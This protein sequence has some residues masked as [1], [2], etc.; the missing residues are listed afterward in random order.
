MLSVTPSELWEYRFGDVLRGLAAL[1]NPEPP[2][3][4][5]PIHGLGPCLGTRSARSA[6]IIAL[7]ALQFKP[8]SRIG[9]PLY[10]CPVVFKAIRMADCTPVFLDIDPMTFCI[11]TK[12]VSAKQ[13]RL[14]ALIAVHMF[15]NVCDMRKLRE[16]MNDRP[17][18]EDCAQSLGSRLDGRLT[19]SFGQVSFFMEMVS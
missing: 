8:G 14:E 2:N 15:G 13:A 4:F 12:D 9:V 7:K 16:I 3:S 6:I 5:V 18:I 11:S 10:C 19:G 1:L 17:I